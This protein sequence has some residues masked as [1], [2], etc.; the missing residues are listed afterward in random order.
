MAFHKAGRVEEVPPGQTKYLCIDN[1]PLLLANRGGEIY[2]LSGLCPHRLNPLEGAVLWDYLVDCP[3]HHFQYDVRSGENFFPRN[4]Y[5]E[6]LQYLNEQVR[7]LDTYAVE[8]RD[9]E[10]W[11]NLE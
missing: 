9:G 6:D 7:P 4:V 11:V 10:V 2:A 8:I 3:W 5:P 1:R